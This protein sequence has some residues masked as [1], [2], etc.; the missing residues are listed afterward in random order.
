LGRRAGFRDVTEQGIGARLLRKEDDRYMRGRGQFVGDIRL[1]GMREVAFL[2]SPLAHA[3]IVAIQ[4]P[5]A[6][7]DRVFIAED[8]Q[9]VAPIRADTALPGFKPSVQ[10]ILATGKV[11]YVGELVA[12]CVAPTRAE[13]EDL[14]AEIDVD[15]EPLPVVHD[16]LAGRKPG[17]PLV[18]EHW[19]DNLFL[20]SFT[21]VNFEA[22]KAKS[23]HTVTRELRTARQAMCP[24]EGRGVLATWNTRLDQLQVTSS[25]QQPHIVRSGLSE[26]LG[27]DEGQIHVV[28]PDVGG[29]FGYKGIL[30]PEEVA[31]AW[32]TR[33]LGAPLRWIEDRREGLTANAN[34]REHHYIITAYADADGRLLALDCEATVDSGAY[35]AYPFSACLEAGQIGSILPG[36]YD[37]PHY[38]CRTYSVATNKPPILP[39]RGVARTGVC[40]ALEVTLDT[41]ARKIGIDPNDLRFKS[42][43]QPGQMP[44]DNVAKRHFDS[45]DYP[46]ALRRAI[47]AIGSA[48]IRARQAAGEPDGR[49]IGIGFAMYSEQAGHGTSVYAAW[50][51]PFV[52]GHEQC[53]ARFT[54][55]GGLELRI[56]AHSHGQGL[57]TTLSQVAHTI[58]GVPHDRIRVIHGDT[59]LTPYSTG[60]WGS[61]C[62]IMSGGAVAAA[63]DELADRVLGIGAKLLQARREDVRIENGTVVG[64][65]GRIPVA[66]VAR[67]WYRRPQDLPPD[68]NPGGLEVT[69]GYKAKRDTGTFS[70]AAHATVVAVDPQTGEIEILDYVVVED[71][72]VLVNPMIVDGQVFGG[73]AQGIGTALYEEMRY[74]AQG[75]PLASTLSDY[76]L[77]GATE[78]PEIRILH[79]ETPSPYTRFGQKG[80]GEGGAIAPP[81]AITNAINDAL[82]DLGVEL[83]VSPITP[84]RIVEAIEQARAGA[85]A[86]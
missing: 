24:L 14:A 46:E 36:L 77:P 60:T 31:L 70:Y 83:L 51:I 37:F 21:D 74:D 81:A 71:G 52:P 54:P 76:I 53:D 80:I 35:S 9:G 69:S 19:G 16:M 11:R 44:F 25:T 4:I 26:C 39:Y 23:V 12:M 78:V 34:C 38:R 68:I 64:P 82:K 75:Q 57:E 73:T 42:L 45:G 49:R 66:E 79:M 6:I 63:C 58:L 47:N 15:F 3:R 17:A 13:A 62:M 1:P 86:T 48:K 20:T 61:R 59:A 33:K 8:L 27:L 30:L 84:R 7:R 22:A 32:A 65:S 10:P 50:G 40:F 41:L 56:G 43:V 72:G 55:D 28:A 85:A 29:G 2:R 67:T 18:H 5:P